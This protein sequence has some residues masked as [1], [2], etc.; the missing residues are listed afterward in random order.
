MNRF[1]R[2]LYM[3]TI[4]QAAQVFG[5]KG[6]QSRS[7]RK[8]Q[9]AR[10]NVRKGREKLALTRLKTLRETELSTIKTDQSDPAHSSQVVENKPKESL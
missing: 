3:I 8:R 7:E 6:G 4:E 1:D 10:E 5:R 9:A 2:I